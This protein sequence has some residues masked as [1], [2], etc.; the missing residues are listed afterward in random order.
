VISTLILEPSATPIADAYREIARSAERTS[1]HGTF[2]A[3]AYDPASLDGARAHWRRRMVDE[4]ESTTVFSSLA[5]Q[6]V[7]AN[8]SLDASVVMLR[9]AQDE[10]RHAEVCAKVARALGAPSHAT[11]RNAVRPLAVH[12]GCSPEERAMRNVL[13]TAISESYSA[14]FFVASLDR[15]TDPYLRSITRELLGDEVLHA[16]FGFWYLQA[17]SDWLARRPDVRASVSL[18]LRRVFAVCEHEHI[19]PATRTR[20]AD[21][22]RL[23]LVPSDVQREMFHATMAEAVAP[24][25]DRF[26]LDATRA[27]HDRHG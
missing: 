26:G 1:E 11:R 25:L 13:V 14:A 23:G 15:M 12:A 20:G 16:R 2:D 8:A 24:A 6:L 10:F 22:D 7:E 18:Y 5:A 21:D 9:M 17:W 19:K 27:W 3:S 4:Y